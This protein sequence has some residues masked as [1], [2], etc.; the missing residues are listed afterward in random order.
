MYFDALTM[1][2]VL[3][4]IRTHL[5]DGRVQNIVA[6]DPLTLGI[7]IYAGGRRHYLLLSA[8]ATLAR[9]HLTDAAVRR[10]MEEPPPLLLQLRKRVRGGRLVAAS[11]PSYE[12]I[13]IIEFAHPQWGESRLIAECMGRHSNIVLTDAEDTILECIKRIGQ[14]RNRYRVLLPGRPYVPPP[15]QD[16]IAPDEL[17]G[18]ALGEIFRE[19]KGDAPAWEVLVRGVQGIS[20]LLAREICS[21]AWG[22]SL[23]ACRDVS[24]PAEAL[25]VLRALWAVDN[26]P[27][28]QPSVGM[29]GD[30]PCFAPYALTHCDDVEPQPS[31]SRAIERWLELSA[32]EAGDPYGAA[33]ARVQALIDAAIERVERRRAQLEAQ[34]ADHADVEALREAGELILAYAWGLPQGESLLQVDL[35]EGKRREIPVDPAL[36]PAENA[37]Q[38][39]ERYQKAKRAAEKVPAL[40]HE[41]EEELAY[42]HQIRLDLQLAHNR[43][44]IDAVE[45]ELG[46]MGY[47]D[48]PRQRRG[49]PPDAGPLSFVTEDGF[50]ILVGRNSR[51]NEE[52]TF[53]IA[54]GDDLWLHARGI[55]GA[56]VI[57]RRA[58]RD[59]SEKAVR[60]A[61]ELA[62]FYS[63]AREDKSVEVD[64]TRRQ[65]VRRR[66]GGRPGQV[67]YRDET[68]LVVAPRP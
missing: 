33:R 20:P 35:G 51:Q 49:L 18:E 9:V 7:E 22:D 48:T 66:P 1:A 23:I 6:V 53:R 16:K 12:R 11:G 21:R 24:R 39:F 52:V 56:H 3:D 67:T 40:L 27:A 28:W 46:R 38:Y 50:T 31:I 5:E 61:A 62:A 60:R 54:R 13:A 19:A 58:G 26:M 10:G 4:E 42:L 57:V 59:P 2:A 17:D 65:F 8:D 64:V 43:P 47:A 32:Q 37:N 36:S 29:E 55:P 25:P 63:S 15:A 34:R 14:T 45:A 30:K 41:S 44:E 68:T